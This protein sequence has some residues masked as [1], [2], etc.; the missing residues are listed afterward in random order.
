MQ[1][2]FQ[3]ISDDVTQTVT[4]LSMSHALLKIQLPPHDQ[5]DRREFLV[6]PRS[7][8]MPRPVPRQV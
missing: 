3:H 5:F 4:L 7:G 1:A 6:V 2:R 8:W